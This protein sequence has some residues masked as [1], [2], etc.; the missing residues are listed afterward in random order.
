MHKQLGAIFLVAGTCIGSGM[1][2]LPIVLAQLGIFFGSMLM[3]LIWLLMYY[4]SLINLELNLQS[5]HG[6]SLGELGAYFSGPIAKAVGVVCLKLLSYALLAVFI[7]GGASVL[8]QLLASRAGAEESAFFLIVSACALAAALILMLPVRWIDYLNRLLFCGL[9]LIFVFLILGLVYAIH[10]SDLPLYTH[11]YGHMSA[12]SDAIPVV[13]TSFGFQV[14]FHTLTNYCKH[15]AVMLKKAFLWGSAIPA[16][17]YIVWT[18]SILAVVHHA[19]PAF[20]QQMMHGNVEVGQLVNV[21]SAQAPSHSVQVLVWW[22][23]LLAIATSLLGVGV[24]LCDTIK[25]MLAGYISHQASCTA[26]ASFLTI[27]PGYLVALM[28]PNA[29]ISVLAFAGMILAIIAILLP[30]YL[31]SRLPLAKYY[32]ET[33]LRPLLWLSALSGCLVIVAELWNAFQG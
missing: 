29:F 17:I 20:Y 5:G 4:T 31:F 21:L 33:N 28:V 23:S 7:Y 16:I 25:G 22:M 14:I 26:L 32:P 2:A 15:D 12:W 11:Q 19:A 10:W 27:L 1:I 30:L 6:R 8:Q 3:L 13:F 9:L 24:G 18:C